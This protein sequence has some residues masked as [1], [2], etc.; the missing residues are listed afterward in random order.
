MKNTA[1]SSGGFASSERHPDTKPDAKELNTSG[2]LGLV[3]SGEPEGVD[4]RGEDA[5]GAAMPEEST[6]AGGRMGTLSSPSPSSCP[7]R[8]S[9]VRWVHCR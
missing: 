6:V 7:H 3:G 1:T 8:L 5:Y 2:D 4:R 9:N